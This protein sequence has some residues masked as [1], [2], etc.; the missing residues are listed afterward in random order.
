MLQYA[1]TD[2]RRAFSGGETETKGPEPME[3]QTDDIMEQL[4]KVMRLARRAATDGEKRAAE[5]AAERIAKK[6]GIDLGTVETTDAD[7]KAEFDRGGEEWQ[8]WPGRETFYV[9]SVL[10][11]HF[12]VILVQTRRGRK[13][14]F[15]WVGT[16]INIEI[17]KHVTVILLRFFKR[18][19]ENA[20]RIRGM[21]NTLL[22]GPK[23]YPQAERERL[24][25]Y[26]K[27]TKGAFMDGWFWTIHQKL[28]EHP[29]RNDREQF[30]AERKAAEDLLKRM[31][32]ITETDRTP[33]EVKDRRSVKLGFEAAKKVNLSRPCDGVSPAV[34]SLL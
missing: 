19:W 8:T 6:H 34:R 29:L 15:E 26:G 18:D 14:R 32:D 20:K 23:S 5:A 7:V 13:V 24:K 10:R 27:L 3:K 4:R 22:T 21:A 2:R 11:Q 12:G 17:A 9:T 1:P 16:K 30:E 25:G 33:K 31:D 28:R